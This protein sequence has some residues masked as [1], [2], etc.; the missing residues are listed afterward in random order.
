MAWTNGSKSFLTTDDTSGDS[1]NRLSEC[2]RENDRD[3]DC[4]Q[5][6]RT[7]D[8]GVSDARVSIEKVS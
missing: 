3:T 1:A 6:T 5:E 2:D 4:M 7:E 8:S